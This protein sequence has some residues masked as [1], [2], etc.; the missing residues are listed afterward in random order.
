MIYVLF[1]QFIL[2]YEFR[3]ETNDFMKENTLIK[4]YYFIENEKD[5]IEKV[6]GREINWIDDEKNPT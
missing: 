5:E 4:T 2:L 6:E 1:L 3:F